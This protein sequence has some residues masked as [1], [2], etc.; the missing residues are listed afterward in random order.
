MD[1]WCPSLQ[2]S[3]TNIKWNINVNGYTTKTCFK[4][5]SGFDISWFTDTHRETLCFAEFSIKI[6]WKTKLADSDVF[7]MFVQSI[8]FF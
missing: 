7:L 1:D 8:K 5:V 2:G 6:N 3:K 4:D